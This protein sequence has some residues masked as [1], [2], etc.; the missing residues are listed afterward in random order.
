MFSVNKILDT[1]S[2]ILQY[3][4]MGYTYRNIASKLHISSATISKIMKGASYHV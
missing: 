3:R 2:I 4:T 1:K